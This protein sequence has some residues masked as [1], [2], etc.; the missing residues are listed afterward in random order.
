[1]HT[2][3]WAY[4]L[5][6][7]KNKLYLSTTDGFNFDQQIRFQHIYKKLKIAEIHINTRYA[8]E[9]SQLHIK[10]A[11][12]FFFETI[13]FFL[14]KKRIVSHKIVKYLTKQNLKKK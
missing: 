13:I 7:F 5:N 9:R 14:I 6:N 11:I 12:R 10:Y 3:Y 4:K 1:M 2:G 8:D